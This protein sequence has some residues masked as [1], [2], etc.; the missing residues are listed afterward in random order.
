MNQFQQQFQ[1]RANAVAPQQ[2]PAGQVN[3]LACFGGIEGANSGRAPYVS[4]HAV[5][6]ID[7][8]KTIYSEIKRKSFLII[9]AVC[10]KSYSD[11]FGVLPGSPGYNGLSQGGACSICIELIEN[12][13]LDLRH[14]RGEISKILKAIFP[15]FRDQ[16]ITLEATLWATGHDADGTPN[17]TQ[18]CRGRTLLV[19][20]KPYTTQAGKTVVLC[21]YDATSDL[22]TFMDGLPQAERDMLLTASNVNQAYVYLKQA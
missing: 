14:S 6:M 10:L 7:N 22:V 12:A 13:G 4:G 16:P 1:P 15:E 2:R 19:T 5:V 8:V 3:V 17:G 20:P 21:N 9:D 18:P 11:N